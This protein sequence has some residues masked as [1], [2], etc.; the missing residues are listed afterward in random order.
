[1]KLAQERGC[2]RGGGLTLARSRAGRAKAISLASEL[3]ELTTVS[4]APRT[5]RRGSQGGLSWMSASTFL[6]RSTSWAVGLTGLQTLNLVA[7]AAP[8]TLALLLHRPLDGL[9][10][11]AV[12]CA[13]TLVAR[14]EA[15]PQ[16]AQLALDPERPTS[17][18]RWRGGRS[19]LR[20]RR[21]AVDVPVTEAGSTS[22][23]PCGGYRSS[24]PGVTI[25]CSRNAFGS[26]L[27]N[28]ASCPVSPCEPRLRVGTPQDRDLK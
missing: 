6:A 3:W 24:V 16:A 5:G 23:R 27:G 12:G 7:A 22:W 1:V 2:L 11:A 8:V 14:P 28:A 26:I 25:P 9:P 20:A 19:A 18:S 4:V 10:G 17:G 13:R 21:R 15:M